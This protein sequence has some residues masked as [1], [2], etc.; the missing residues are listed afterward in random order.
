MPKFR[1]KPVEVEAIKFL[2]LIEGDVPKFEG[3]PPEWLA[4]AFVKD[5]FDDGALF[6]HKSHNIG[7][8]PGPALLVKTLEGSMRAMPGDWLVRG[9][10]GE[11]YPCKPDR[12]ADTYDYCGDH[13]V[14]AGVQRLMDAVKEE[15]NDDAAEQP[16][17]APPTGEDGGSSS[18]P[19]CGV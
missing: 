7:G 12:F 10:R 13:D 15:G 1:K 14:D 9:T 16:S 5:R 19:L 2:G 8:A 18:P 4:E 6:V 17:P 11:L 3:P